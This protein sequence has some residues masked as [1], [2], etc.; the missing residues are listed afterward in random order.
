MFRSSLA[1]RR[2]A[3]A[4]LAVNILLVITGGAVRLTSSGLGCPTWPKC[5]NS[6]YVTTQAMGYHGMI[7][8]GNR[9]L[10]GADGV[11]AAL[12]VLLVLLSRTRDRRLI[13]WSIAVLASIPA[14]AV[15]GGLTVRT[16]LNPWVV[17]CHFL[18]SMLI[19]VATYRLWLATRE[20]AGPV[21]HLVNAPIR[22]LN[23]LLLAVTAV[24]LAAGTVVTGS[25][26]HAGDEHVHHR[27]GLDP[28]MVAQL[29]ADLVM[30][31]IGLSAAWCFALWAVGA[32]RATIR[33]GAALVGIEL[34]QGVIGFVQYFTHLPSLLVG[35]HMAGA[36]A[37]WTAALVTQTAGRVREPLPAASEA[38]VPAPV[39]P[40]TA[41]TR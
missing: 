35:L 13:G 11:L 20:P 34:A 5:T 12:A 19:I 21:R 26:P 1:L 41:A 15:I 10:G 27:T 18:F 32:P 39:L 4:S 29:H 14:Q 38:P 37:V 25:G 31:L 6:S 23:W 2:V 9:I 28:G 40:A 3:L 16:E 30:L 22:A 17:A 8:F 36:C 33:A 7:E 24:V